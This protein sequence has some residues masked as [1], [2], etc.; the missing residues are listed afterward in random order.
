MN[1]EEKK[2][3]TEDQQGKLIRKIMFLLDK[4]Y[5]LDETARDLAF[6]YRENLT[7]LA[8]E[9]EHIAITEMLPAMIDMVQSAL[10]ELENRIRSAQTTETKGE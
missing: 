1:T 5:K 9:A 6:V 10:Y 3:M 4:A 2:A 7:D 8:S